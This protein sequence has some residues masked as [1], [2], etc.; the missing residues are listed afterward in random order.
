VPK[1]KNKAVK[2]IKKRERFTLTD[3]TLA[4]SADFFKANGFYFSVLTMLD[5]K[6]G[7]ER[8]SDK[9]RRQIKERE[10]AR[11]GAGHSPA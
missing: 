6:T 10:G 3:R 1:I 4:Q 5:S 11:W 9:R 7:V 8:P 2:P